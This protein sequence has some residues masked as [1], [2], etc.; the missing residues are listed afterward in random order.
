MEPRRLNALEKYE[1]LESKSDGYCQKSFYRQQLDDRKTKKLTKHTKQCIQITQLLYKTRKPAQP[2]QKAQKPPE[3]PETR[4]RG[5]FRFPIFRITCIIRNIIKIKNRGPLLLRS[6]IGAGFGSL[7][8]S[9]IS[10]RLGRVDRLPSRHHKIQLD[11]TAFMRAS[12]ASDFT[13]VYP[14]AVFRSTRRSLHSKRAPLS[15]SLLRCQTV[16]RP[17]R[18]SQS[19]VLPEPPD[20]LHLPTR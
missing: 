20:S 19:T 5:L 10:F 11:K 1:R 14:T 12:I 18:W 3:R 4:K 17:L 7:C 16:Q 2:A 13:V 6:V 15:Y 8:C 9:F